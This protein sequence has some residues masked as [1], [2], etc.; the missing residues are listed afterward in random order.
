MC[1]RPTLAGLAV[2]CVAG[3]GL[4]QG[5]IFE[6]DFDGYLAAPCEGADFP[7]SCQ[8][9]QAAFEAVWPAAAPASSGQ[10]NSTWS[11]CPSG[12]RGWDQ[13]F[14][15]RQGGSSP[16]RNVRDLADVTRQLDPA[17]NAINGSDTQ[18]LVLNF[19]VWLDSGGKQFRTS[20]YLD[21]F[22]LDS[23]APNTD[24][25]MHTSCSVGNASPSNPR[26]ALA[27][28]FFPELVPKQECPALIKELYAAAVYA[29]DHWTLLKDNVPTTGLQCRPKIK[30]NEFTLTI[31]ETSFDL[32]LTNVYEDGST[33]TASRVGIPR[34]YNGPFTTLGIGAGVNSQY[35]AW[36]DRVRINGG[37][38]AYI[39][40]TGACCLPSGAC[41][42]TGSSLCAAQAG[43]F[44]GANTTCT[45][46]TAVECCPNPFADADGDTDVD[47]ADFAALQ[48]CLT[49][50][51]TTMD[52]DCECFDVVAPAG[53]IDISDIER[54]ALCGSGPGIPA[55]QG[56]DDE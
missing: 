20:V 6:E 51:G 18:P 35:P 2:L 9:D 38:A 7:C 47:A 28:G 15:Y 19:H 53:V 30:D 42:E 56:C 8:P 22:A 24:K 32:S 26:K 29:G 16:F 40:A 52:L 41:V 55:D 36:I 11:T 12:F 10:V 14:S 50:P 49:A 45:G 34:A 21:L 44:N 3:S 17:A 39:E 25:L 54:F 37:V 33:V 4:A 1:R 46:P 23:P 43:T 13:P 5:V 31:R 27:I 48:R